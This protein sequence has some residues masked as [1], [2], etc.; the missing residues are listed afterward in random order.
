[1]TKKMTGSV[2]ALIRTKYKTLSAAQKE[3]ADYVLANAETVMTSSLND[4]ATACNV[5][6]TTIIRFLRKLD[7]DSYQLLRVHIAQELSRSKGE[8]IYEE[9]RADDGV[10]D[11]IQK[12]IQSTARSITDSAEII[13][14]VQLDSI[15]ER[16]LNSRRVF[17][18]GIGASAA[19]TYDLCHKLLKL[20]L[21]A[22]YSHDPHMI[23]IQCYGMTA[24]DVLVVFSH[25]GESRE[26]LDGAAYAKEQGALV[27]SV[28]SY[29]RSSLAVKS[30]YVLLSSSL[31]TRYRSDA[32]TSRI[33]QITI[34]DMIYIS[35]ALRMGESGL[36]RINRSRVAVAKNK[37]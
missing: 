21:N 20:S 11:V 27:V 4:L 1:M 19:M 3:V 32:M 2:F 25:T 10:K 9:V 17:I 37:T 14:P 8:D 29:A 31:E 7:Y 18:I 13:D 34:I 5:S 22:S 26:V 30:D 15:V 6:E 12:V 23:N 24:Q 33:I 28:T 35:L 36:F 16:I